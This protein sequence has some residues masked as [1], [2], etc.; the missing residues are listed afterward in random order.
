MTEGVAVIHRT[1]GEIH[2]S[3]PALVALG[4]LA[5][6]GCSSTGSVDSVSAATGDDGWIRRGEFVHE[7]LLTGELQAVRSVA[8]K[9][10]QTRIFQMRL[11]FMAKEG[12]FVKAGDDLLDFDNSALAEQVRDLETRILD[13]KM[14]IVARKAELASALK[15]LEIEIAEKE[16]ELGR[17]RLDAGVDPEVLSDEE[18]S[19][20]QLTYTKAQREMQETL[21]RIEL[22]RERG[23]AEVD[24]LMIDRD[25]LE[26]DLYGA[27]DG[28]QL[29][30]IK[31][32]SDG[33]VIYEKR[34]G[35]T[36]RYQEGD[37]CWPGQGI[38]RLP[39]L[40]DM[41]AVM[42]VNEVDAPQLE[43]GMSV[44]ISLDAFPGRE[45]TGVVRHIPSMAVKRDEDSKVAIFRVITTLS[46]TWVGEM[47]PGMSA[48]G[49]VVLERRE[50]APLILRALVQTDGSSYWVR[51]G[52]QADGDRELITP[53]ARNATH[54]MLSEE[55]Y[56]RLAGATPGAKERS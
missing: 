4:S 42:L 56:A 14:Q 31:A 26:A 17:A 11:Q 45:L 21:T 5:L 1:A 23:Q 52:D 29:L 48:R 40:S 44:A 16:Y 51:R 47:K 6:A 53:L 46:E 2:R 33:L 38:I 7:L 18:H 9:S 43:V 55:D 15:D 35:T 22:T 41:E 54:Y 50:D 19:E 12:S 10:P 36:L 30:S 37:S 27:Q 25:K 39:D 20:R 32:P 24:V 49:L 8:I 34:Q 13:A 28:L 3:L